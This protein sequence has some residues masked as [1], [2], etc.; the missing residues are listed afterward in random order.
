MKP[1]K[2]LKAVIPFH[3]QISVINNAVG[4]LMGFGQWNFQMEG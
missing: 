3:F 4:N 2:E 1:A